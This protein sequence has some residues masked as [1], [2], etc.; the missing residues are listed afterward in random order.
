MVG[1]V[2]LTSASLLFVY[3][4]AWYLVGLKRHQLNVVDVAW[5]GAFIIVAWTAY[6]L[7]QVPRNLTV[8]VLVSLWGLRLISHLVR[9]VW[10]GGEDPRYAEIMGRWEKRP[11][12]RAYVSIF[13]L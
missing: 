10:R 4:T 11:W 13:L 6:A 2:L 8:A 12:L 3:M 5:G 9:R 7:Y 1:P